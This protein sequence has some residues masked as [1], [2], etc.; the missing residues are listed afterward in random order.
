MPDHIH[1]FV[2]GGV[3]FNLGVW[4]RGLKRATES[5]AVGA[6][7]AGG[8]K[9]WQPGFFDHILRNDESYSEKWNYVRNNP[10]RARLVTD[11]GKWAFQGEISSIDE[12]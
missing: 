6:A 2:R 12:A 11:A 1:L 4:I 7:V 3:D 9:I 10:V 5:A 8:N